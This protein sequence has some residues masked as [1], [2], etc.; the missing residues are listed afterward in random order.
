[1]TRTL[2]VAALAAAFAVPVS[3]YHI[4]GNLVTGAVGA[5]TTSADWTLASPFLIIC[6]SMGNGVPAGPNDDRNDNPGGNPGNGGLCTTGRNDASGLPVPNVGGVPTKPGAHVWTV[7]NSCTATTA[8]RSGGPTGPFLGGIGPACA[9]ANKAQ[10]GFDAEL[11]I[12]SCTVGVGQSLLYNENY[13]WLTYDGDGTYYSIPNG[14]AGPARDAPGAGHSGDGSVIGTGASPSPPGSDLADAWDGHLAMFIDTA[15]AQAAGATDGSAE[16]SP[17]GAIAV[18]SPANDCSGAGP[19]C[20]P[21]PATC[22]GTTAKS[23]LIVGV[24]GT[25][26]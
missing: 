24:Q 1:M 10:V 26:F 11:G 19:A 14:V 13:A 12:M 2:A 5:A 20:N 17:P 15:S 8:G 9:P 18:T 6:E 23:P 21:A 25:H 7:L 22:N 3:G 4:D 16:T